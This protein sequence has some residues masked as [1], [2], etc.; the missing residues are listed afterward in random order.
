MLVLLVEV[1]VK[2]DLLAEFSAAILHNATH[3]VRNDVGCFRFDVSQ[4]PEE[5]T[6]WIFHEVY[7]SADAHQ[8]HRQSPHFL[9]YQAVADRA[10]ERKVLTRWESRH[11]PT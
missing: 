11:V 7:A 4:H 3:S 1:T 8:A 9:A 5:P 2:P 6:R 10:V